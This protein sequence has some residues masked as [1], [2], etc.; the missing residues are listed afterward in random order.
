MLPR[1][2]AND[3]WSWP[4]A[5]SDDAVTGGFNVR[6]KFWRGSGIHVES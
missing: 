1:L 4:R 6:R 3:Y 5:W 2:T